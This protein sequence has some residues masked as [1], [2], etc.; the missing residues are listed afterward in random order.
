MMEMLEIH[1]E[2]IKIPEFS[3]ITDYVNF[4]GKT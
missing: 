2:I 3:F 4:I 1:R